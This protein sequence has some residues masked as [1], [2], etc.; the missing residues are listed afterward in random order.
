VF[1]RAWDAFP[2]AIGTIHDSPQ[3]RTSAARISRITFGHRQYK[4]PFQEAIL[5]G[6]RI[7]PRG[8]WVKV[9]RAEADALSGPG[10]AEQ[11]VVVE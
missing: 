2:Q 1:G 4:G 5:D 11:V 3:T 8:E 10:L 7:L 6:G 9:S